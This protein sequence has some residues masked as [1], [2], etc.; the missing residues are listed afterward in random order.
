MTAV[1]LI[2]LRRRTSAEFRVPPN[3]PPKTECT[4]KPAN[5]KSKKGKS[6]CK[7]PTKEGEFKTQKQQEEH[8]EHIYQTIQLSQPPKISSTSKRIRDSLMLRRKSL[9]PNLC[10]STSDGWPVSEEFEDHELPGE[11]HFNDSSL[12]KSA[13]NTYIQLELQNSNSTTYD[14]VADMFCRSIKDLSASLK[15]I[16]T[17]LDVEQRSSTNNNS[18]AEVRAER[19]WERAP[20]IPSSVDLRIDSIMNEKP[21]ATEIVN[22]NSS[23]LTTGVYVPRIKLR[24]KKRPSGI[25]CGTNI[26][27]QQ[28]QYAS[29][30]FVPQY[31][32]FA[33]NAS[34]S[35][36]AL[37]IRRRQM[38]NSLIVE[39]TTKNTKCSTYEERC[40]DCGLLG[41]K[42]QH[43]RCS[44]FSPKLLSPRRKVAPISSQFEHLIQQQ[45]EVGKEPGR[46]ASRWRPRPL[47]LMSSSSI[48]SNIFT[49]LPFGKSSKTSA[50]SI[51]DPNPK[52]NKNKRYSV[53]V[54]SFRWQS[55]SAPEFSALK[56]RS[57]P[58]SP[59]STKT[60]Q[61]IKSATASLFGFLFGPR[62]RQSSSSPTKRPSSKL[63]TLER[64]R[65]PIL[66]SPSSALRPLEVIDEAPIAKIESSSPSSSRESDAQHNTAKARLGR[67]WT[68]NSYRR[69][70]RRQLQNGVAFNMCQ[71][72][73]EL[74]EKS[75]RVVLGLGI[76]TF[77]DW[78]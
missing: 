62:K 20:T 5:S 12:K 41:R 32:I 58:F 39:D 52:F 40:I 21:R 36:V 3:F 66:G 14:E 27:K 22:N 18:P 55:A 8:E 1:E 34:E 60:A 4:T 64:N 11:Q 54:E 2:R 33:A 61:T 53:S 50:S 49:K 75:V 29:T 59:P 72:N 69:A 47:S 56:M 7:N 17:E 23:N 31:P 67:K 37:A 42:E 76:V 38:A 30:S 74:D 51:I 77:Y 25:V 65:F 13:S 16:D 9:P 45:A 35:A 15:E 44:H 68:R 71:A 28:Q 43:G 19:S 24:E 6:S 26:S 78:F 70:Q 57:R 46:T 63:I 48:S 10:K 73:E